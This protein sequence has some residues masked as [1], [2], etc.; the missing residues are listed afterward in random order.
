MSAIQ[1]SLGTLFNVRPREWRPLLLF[2]SYILLM[3]ADM[4]LLRSFSNAVFLA[5]YDISLLPPVFIASS[6]A[7][8]GAALWYNALSARIP[9]KT[10]SQALPLVFITVLALM[11]LLMLLEIPG[12]IFG[13]YV[14]VFVVAEMITIVSW[15]YA[16]R[17]FDIRQMKRLMP[18]LGAMGSAGAIGG[19]MLARAL[20]PAI[21]TDELVVVSMLLL[22]ATA[23]LVRLCN[24]R[25]EDPRPAKPSRTSF[26][27][28]MTE[29]FGLIGRH[30]L[31]WRAT[32]TMVLALLAFKVLDY[33]FMVSLKLQFDKDTIAAFLGSFYSVYNLL[34]MLLQLFFLGRLVK[35]FGL[36]GAFLSRPVGLMVLAP[37]V[38][39][40]PPFWPIVAMMFLDS[41]LR[42][43]WYNVGSNLVIAPVPAAMAERIKIT[44]S[45][46]ISPLATVGVSAA[47]M[48]VP[49]FLSL[50]QLTWIVL[51][52][53]ALWIACSLTLNRHYRNALLHA[54]RSRTLDREPLLDLQRVADP[55]TVANVAEQLADPEP[56]TIRFGLRLTADMRLEGLWARVEELLAHPLPEIRQAA[57]ETLAALDPSRA[58]R[59]TCGRLHKETHPETLQ[60]LLR[61]LEEADEEAVLEQARRFLDHPEPRVAADAVVLLFRSGSL[62]WIIPAAERLGTLL[63]ADEPERAAAAAVLGRLGLAKLDRTLGALLEDPSPEVRR[64][65]LPAAAHIPSPA[66]LHRVARMLPDAQYREAA[67]Q[68]LIQAGEAGA[69]AVLTLCEEAE[70]PLAAQLS[71][72]RILRRSPCAGALTHLGQWLQ[73]PAEALRLETLKTLVHFARAGLRLNPEALDASFLREAREAFFCRHFE[74]SAPPLL[75]RELKLR[76]EDAV[77]RLLTCLRLSVDAETLYQVQIALLSREQMLRAKALELLDTTLHRPLH[78]ICLDLLDEISVGELYR[79]CRGPLSLEAREQITLPAFASEDP[80]LRYLL[81]D[82]PPPGC[83]AEGLRILRA[84]T[85]TALFRSLRL[86]K[87][88]EVALTG[89][90]AHFASGE[91]LFS[92][93][94]P[95]DQY[96]VIL[97]G[98]IEI[99]VKELRVNIWEAGGALGETAPLTGAPRNATARS[100]AATEC[101]VLSR[102]DF[103][104]LFARS[105]QVSQ[106]VITFLLKTLEDSTRR[107]RAL[108]EELARLEE[109]P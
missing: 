4:I 22:A 65:A 90:V 42:Y 57:C 56:E 55:E 11:R 92:E 52:A 7:T 107:E 67:Q 41:L 43:S 31:M 83:D 16:R 21:G 36:P 25:I 76:F 71:A 86:E 33:Q 60:F 29:G 59:A 12:F 88:Y 81:E 79:R 77:K 26:V 5:A 53:S 6:L 99:Y 104:V 103:Q 15:N 109:A 87:L 54:I 108:R 23:L 64:Q 27:R 1:K 9:F 89:R 39:L 96:Y 8:C 50:P 34:L 51:G 35:R 30:P 85:E 44:Q 20:A 45:G 69:A 66:T 78:R 62:D 38:L 102:K 68:A 97:E 70:T 82:E 75:A 18:I 93:G 94:E 61:H 47:L 46:V 101:F 63:K 14:V 106:A 37:A 17:G 72:A 24:Q 2:G 19:G 58:A 13:L 95:G 80:W 3:I 100:A 98:R 73:S 28:N 105:V 32:L 91:T 49:R 84:L 74:A 40:L 10:L 48:V